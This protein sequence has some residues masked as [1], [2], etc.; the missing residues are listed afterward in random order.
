MFAKDVELQELSEITHLSLKERVFTNC[1]PS[2]IGMHETALRFNYKFK[3][4]TASL[5]LVG[6]VTCKLD[7][8]GNLVPYISQYLEHNL[9][10]EEVI[11]KKLNEFLLTRLHVI[12]LCKLST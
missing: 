5:Q 2:N 8:I 7:F 10:Q 9:S 1:I 4:S 12:I 11:K 3:V 6:R